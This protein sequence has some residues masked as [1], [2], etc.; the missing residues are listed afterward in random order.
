[1]IT[2]MKM[3]I[4]LVRDYSCS[5]IILLSDES[6][7]ITGYTVY[8]YVYGCERKNERTIV[9]VTYIMFK[10]VIWPQ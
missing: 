8:V 5:G 3:G 6:V 1:M 10:E 7:Y 4:L 9:T 2:I